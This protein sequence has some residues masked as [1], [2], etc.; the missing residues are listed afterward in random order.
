MRGKV[1]SVSKGRWQA[2]RRRWKNSKLQWI[3]IGAFRWDYCFSDEALYPGLANRGLTSTSSSSGASMRSVALT[4]RNLF[5]RPPHWKFGSPLVGLFARCAVLRI[6]MGDFFRGPKE[7]DV[8]GAAKPSLSPIADAAR[9]L[10]LR[11]ARVPSFPPGRASVAP[12]CVFK[13]RRGR[14]RTT[15]RCGHASPRR[16]PAPPEASLNSRHTG[17]LGFT[18]TCE[19]GHSSGPFGQMPRRK[20]M[21]TGIFSGDT[22]CDSKQLLS[23]HSPRRNAR[24]TATRAGS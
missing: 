14:S 7:I 18:R 23:T 19:N 15:W 13:R 6:R 21:H 3:V 9:R 12:S 17:A 16:H 22:L 4:R 10:D 1:H 2:N 24:H 11:N 5:R 8:L 20:K